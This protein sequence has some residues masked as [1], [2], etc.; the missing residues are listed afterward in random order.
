MDWSQE[1][2]QDYPTTTVTMALGDV[3][4]DMSNVFLHIKKKK[5][6]ILWLVVKHD[7]MFT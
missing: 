3:N 2:L 7:Q 4:E 6:R 5:K 1:G